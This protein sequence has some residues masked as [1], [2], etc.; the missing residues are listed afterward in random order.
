MWCLCGHKTW[1]LLLVAFQFRRTKRIRSCIIHIS[2]TCMQACGNVWEMVQSWK[3]ALG[4][5]SQFQ[6]GTYSHHL[7]GNFRQTM[8]QTDFWEGTSLFA[9]KRPRDWTS[10]NAV[11][12]SRTWE[13]SQEGAMRMHH[14][15]RMQP[16]CA[17]YCRYLCSA[18]G[19]QSVNRKLSKPCAHNLPTQTLCYT[20]FTTV[21]A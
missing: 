13:Q 15:I 16:P 4:S 11:W 17:F 8:L 1:L 12:R 20:S 14:T 19:F 18:S 2:S 7:S 9:P 21:S 5:S 6:H 3:T 10:T